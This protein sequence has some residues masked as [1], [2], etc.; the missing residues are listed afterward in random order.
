M[1][2]SVCIIIYLSLSLWNSKFGIPKKNANFWMMKVAK[3]V[4]RENSW[5]FT[6]LI[7]FKQFY[8]LSIF[9][10]TQKSS[11][12]W[13]CFLSQSVVHWGSMIEPQWISRNRSVRGVNIDTVWCLASGTGIQFQTSAKFKSDDAS[14]MPLF[15]T[16]DEKILI[17]WLLLFSCCGFAYT[18]DPDYG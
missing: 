2:P 7:E 15:E 4:A 12:S 3:K 1:W 13:Q 6:K 17:I 10:L 11:A 9:R 8:Q 14:V 16:V 18:Y 5:A